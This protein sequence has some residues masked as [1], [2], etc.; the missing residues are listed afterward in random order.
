MLGS[1]PEVL[2]LDEPS[3]GLELRARHQRLRQGR[4]VGDGRAEDL[5][6]AA[7]LSA[8]CEIPLTGCTVDGYRQVLPTDADT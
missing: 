1:A 7:P 8:H 5:L 3:N 2:V 4:I 6:Q